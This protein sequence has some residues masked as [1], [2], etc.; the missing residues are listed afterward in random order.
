VRKQVTSRARSKRLTGLVLLGVLVACLSGLGL[1][2]LTRGQAG[3]AAPSPG[4]EGPNT[5]S[6]KVATFD[7]ADGVAGV[8]YV[9]SLDSGPFRVCASPERVERL[10]AGRHLFT[11][12]AKDATGQLSAPTSYAWTVSDRIPSRSTADA[13]NAGSSGNSGNAAAALS[14]SGTSSK[15]FYPGTNYP[16]DLTF[17]NSSSASI[18][19][20]SVTVT[21]RPQ[22]SNPHCNA[23]KNYRLVNPDRPGGD[24]MTF[25]RTFV[26]PAG[27]TKSLSELGVPRRGWPEIGMMNLPVSQNA[28]AKASFS[29][30]FA[31]TGPGGES[32][33]LTPPAIFVIG[34]PS[35]VMTPGSQR[36]LFDGKARF[37]ITVRNPTRGRLVN[38]RIR[39]A[40]ARACARSLGTLGPGATRIFS[41]TRSHVRRSFVNAA[42]VTAMAANGRYYSVSDHSTVKTAARARE[43]LTR[44]AGTRKAGTRK[45]GGASHAG[46]K[47]T[48]KTTAPV[49]AKQPPKP[50]VVAHISPEVTG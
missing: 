46:Q 23:M 36:I 18:S 45:A 38:V 10:P 17:D 1:V 16:I 21:I 8:S 13:G 15:V 39:D 7:F 12:T 34:R 41:C 44:K 29:V 26:I 35:L 48:E 28:C 43:T 27:A 50:K 31:Y 20:K 3:E 2:A 30:D 25:D 14:I 22:T 33:P 6:S 4:A 5:T 37:T 32:A 9:C 49:A 40:K 19:V 47:T 11:V 42:L 24:T